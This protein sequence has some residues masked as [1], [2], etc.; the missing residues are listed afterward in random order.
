M[1]MCLEVVDF[2]LVFLR[3]RAGLTCEL[4]KLARKVHRFASEDSMIPHQLHEL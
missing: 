4:T 1:T 3:G 2:G